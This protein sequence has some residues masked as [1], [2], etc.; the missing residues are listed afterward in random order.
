MNFVDC[1][2][3]VFFRGKTALVAFHFK[4]TQIKVSLF[5]AIGVDNAHA[6]LLQRGPYFVSQPAYTDFFVSTYGE[7]CETGCSVSFDCEARGFPPPTYKW[8]EDAS[9]GV[10]CLPC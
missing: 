5:S 8:Y 3:L 7:V 6:D 4:I 10:S 2:C 9:T 1:D